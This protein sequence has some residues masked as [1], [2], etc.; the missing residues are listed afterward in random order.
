MLHEVNKDLLFKDVTL[1]GLNKK[2]SVTRKHAMK[3][4][5]TFLLLDVTLYCV[6]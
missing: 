5:S 2:L 6:K 4:I 3:S 1:Y